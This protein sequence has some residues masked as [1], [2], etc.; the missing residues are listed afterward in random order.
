M[1]SVVIYAVLFSVAT[2]VSILLLGSRE[3]IGGVITPIRMV[4]IIFTWQ[5]ILGAF[6]ALIARLL[7]MLINNALYRRPEFSDSSTTITAL[8]TTVALVFV[9]IAN[10]Y[11]LNEQITF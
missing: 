1:L 3:I 2:V 6:M 9:I 7:F 11:F 8:I 5:F 4:Q 10:Y